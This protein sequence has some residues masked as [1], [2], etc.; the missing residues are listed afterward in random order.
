MGERRGVKKGQEFAAL[1]DMITSAWSGLTTKQYKQLKGLKTESL[2]DNITNLE[3]ALNTLAE[4]TTTEISKVQ[5]P[6]TLNENKN[7]AEKGGK[8]VGNTRKEIEANIGKSIISPINAKT[9]KSM[10]DKKNQE[11][12]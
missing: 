7:V 3:L 5:K 9:I 8:I 2:I 4:A 10:E 1:T 11:K 12:D 6:E